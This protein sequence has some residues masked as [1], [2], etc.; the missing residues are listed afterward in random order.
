[1]KGK[2]VGYIASMNLKI[3]WPSY[4]IQ[5]IQIG[6]I[7]TSF[8][9]NSQLTVRTASEELRSSTPTGSWEGTG[10]ETVW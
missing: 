4:P 6:Q 2:T 9:T 8:S 5:M 3:L 10:L 7:M 1:M